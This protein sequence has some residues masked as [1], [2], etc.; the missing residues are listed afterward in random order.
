MSIA[1]PGIDVDR[2]AGVTRRPEVVVS[3][4]GGAVGAGLLEAAIRAKPLSALRDRTWRVLAGDNV[5]LELSP[6]D[7][8]KGRITFRHLGPR[9]SGAAPRRWHRH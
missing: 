4:G 8:T 6:Y 1:P 9:T 5:S 2:F 7:L 3:A